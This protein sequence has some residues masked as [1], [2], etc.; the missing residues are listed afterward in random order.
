M[1]QTVHDYVVNCK[2]CKIIK[3]STENTR[4]ATGKY[5][6]PLRVGRIL[7][8]DLVGP[9]PASRVHKH[10]MII[11]CVDSFSRYVFTR[12]CTRA[13]ANVIADFLEKEVFY[14]F[15]TPEKIITDNGSQ[16]VSDFF[17]KFLKS[18]RITHIRTPVYHAQPNQ[19]EASN[20][21]IKTLLRAELVKRNEHVDWSSYLHKITMRLN[22]TPRSPTGQS[23]HFLVYGREKRH[24]GDEHRLIVDVNPPDEESDDRRDI[25]YEEAAETQRAQFEQNKNRYN[26]RASVRKFNVGQVVYIK[27]QQQSSAA[28]EHSQKLAPLKRIAV[29]K[30]VVEYASD[31]YRLMDA[32]GKE[33]GTYHAN[34]IFSR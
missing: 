10:T 33:I 25:I 24:T 27:N 30:S 12:A 2:T 29:V 16:F 28:N 7:S 11:V 13:T 18:H 22:T 4:V 32:S 19:V 6:D 34:Q 20:K 5:R 21:C 17:V 1:A 8:L 14:R 26:L 9:L 31:M 15:E 23:P 3:P